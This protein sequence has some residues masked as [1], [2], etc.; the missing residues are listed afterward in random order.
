M[1]EQYDCCPFILM[2]CNVPAARVRL[3]RSQYLFYFVPQQNLTV[4]LARLIEAKIK[5]KNPSKS[6]PWPDRPHF[7]CFVF[8]SDPVFWKRGRLGRRGVINRL[9]YLTP[10]P[11]PQSTPRTEM[12]IAKPPKFTSA[13]ILSFWPTPNA[14]TVITTGRR[15]PKISYHNWCAGFVELN[16]QSFLR[17]HPNKCFHCKCFY[18]RGRHTVYNLSSWPL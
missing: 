5:A 13:L 10:P 2:D 3:Y 12:R 17:L 18:T 4:Q 11:P 1:V 7:P 9:S 16:Y 8:P 14:S 6:S 15:H